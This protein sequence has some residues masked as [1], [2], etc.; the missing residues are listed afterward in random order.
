MMDIDSVRD[1]LLFIH[2]SAFDVIPEYLD[3]KNT[4]YFIDPPYTA[5]GKKAGRRLYSHHELDHD[6]LFDYFKNAKSNFLFTYDDSEDLRNMARSRGYKF[7][8]IPMKNTHH[9]TM[10]ELIIGKDFKWLQN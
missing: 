8:L 10:N 2:G 1:R 4:A 6:K 5:A 9:S 3:D 7:E